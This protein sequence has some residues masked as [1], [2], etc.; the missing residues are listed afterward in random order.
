MLTPIVI[1]TLSTLLGI[2]VLYALYKLYK[3]FFNR[4]GRDRVPSDGSSD[5]NRV[6]FEFYAGGAKK[7]KKLF[8]K[9]RGGAGGVNNREEPSKFPFLLPRGVVLISVLIIV[10]IVSAIISTGGK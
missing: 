1:Y 4:D 5:P 8:K 7:I 3:V 6:S 10:L 2:G 9:K